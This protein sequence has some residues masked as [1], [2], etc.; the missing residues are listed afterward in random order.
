LSETAAQPELM[1]SLRV[2]L[3]HNLS[4]GGARRA[5]HEHELRLGDRLTEFCLQTSAPVTADARIVPFA[6][7]AERMHPVLRPV[8][9][10][11]DLIA[12]V[13]A[14]RELARAV[15]RSASDVVLVHPCQFL[16]APT[17]LRWFRS[18]SVYFCHE[19]RRVDYEEAAAARV[20]PATRHIYSG[21]HRAER[22]LDRSAVA[23]AGTMLTNSRF[24]ATRIER[25]YGRG[26]EPIPLG[27]AEIFREP[28]AEGER[29]HLLSVGSLIPS[30][31]HDLAIR[32]AAL[33]EVRWPLVIVT[34]SVRSEE[35]A[36]LQRIAQDCGVALEI[37]ASVSDV[38][39]RELY[40]GAV[41]TL[42]LALEE[43]LGLASIE[44]QACGSPVVVSDEGGLPET[45]IAG[46]TGWAVPRENLGVAARA[47][48]SL[49]DARLAA[50][51]SQRAREHGRAQTW[52]RSAV[53][54]RETLE[55]AAAR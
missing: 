6:P 25:A 13:R 9:R 52:D 45:M 16:Q 53:R 17:A 42:Y 44:A 12:L 24:T 46:E 11:V 40:R 51:F 1:A 36:R 30:K 37:R 33:A 27:V 2:A 43:P 32:A 15:N 55:L 49:Q 20:N 22:Y 54:M 34:P 5:M 35:G 29:T 39:L 23:A 26:A 14:W 8:P 3:V 31:G 41:A 10:H 19:P 38:E 48:D 7:L 28:A 50:A 21:L 4:R 47:I 18:P